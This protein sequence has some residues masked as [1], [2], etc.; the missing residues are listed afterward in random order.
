MSQQPH[1][2]TPEQCSQ[3]DRV[4]QDDGKVGYAIWYP[5]MGGYVGKAVAVLTRGWP[6]C[7]DVYVWHDG[8]F[9]FVGKGTTCA[10]CDNKIANNPMV[11]HH[12]DANDF[13]RFGQALQ[14]F[15]VL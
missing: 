10:V 9:P 3:N 8:A 11:I 7:F 4:F 15:N 14:G 13:I 5:Q 12:C 1:E 6:E 2:P